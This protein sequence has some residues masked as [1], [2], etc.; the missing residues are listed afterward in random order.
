[1][2]AFLFSAGLSGVSNLISFR[3]GSGLFSFCSLGFTGDAISEIFW[4][5]IDESL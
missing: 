4:G 2:S 3:S 1:M 5:V